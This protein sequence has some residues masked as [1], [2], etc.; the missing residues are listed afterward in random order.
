[1]AGIIAVDIA[2][3]FRQ[4]LQRRFDSPAGVR[5]I[6]G[7]DE[8]ER[9]V[10]GTTFGITRQFDGNDF[11]IRCFDGIVDSHDLRTGTGTAANDT[12]RAE[13]P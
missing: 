12:D 3:I 1:M 10:A 11:R 8:D 9:A 4:D 6:F 5:Y 13:F 7:A 2:E